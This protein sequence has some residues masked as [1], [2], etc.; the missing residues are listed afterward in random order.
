MCTTT[1]SSRG[2]LCDTYAE[3]PVNLYLPA[4][5]QDSAEGCTTCTEA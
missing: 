1:L 2:L 5:L 3:K 4:L